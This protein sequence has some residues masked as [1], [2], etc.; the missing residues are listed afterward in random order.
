MSPKEVASLSTFLFTLTT[1][2]V[3][4][5]DVYCT[6]RNNYINLNFSYL[7]RNKGKSVFRPWKSGVN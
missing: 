2:I 6:L 5:Y 7:A 1:K 3:H 4:K